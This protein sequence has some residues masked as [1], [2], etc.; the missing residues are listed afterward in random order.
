MQDSLCSYGYQ[1]NVPFCPTPIT[2][3]EQKNNCTGT[4]GLPNPAS[5]PWQTIPREEDEI[6]VFSQI[7]Q[8]ILTGFTNLQIRD[9][10]E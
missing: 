7:V 9:L 10:M 1:N 3:G 5:C 4:K 8:S 6:K 2:P